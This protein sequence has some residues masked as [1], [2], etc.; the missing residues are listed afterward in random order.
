MQKNS[1]TISDR[2]KGILSDLSSFVGKDSVALPACESRDR[3]LFVKRVHSFKSSSWFA[4]PC[5]LSPIICAR[6]GWTNI[7]ID[8]LHCVGCQSLLVVRAP[9][10]FDPA[11]Y[12]ACQKRL[13]DQLKRSA[14]HPCCMWPSCPTPEVIILA[15]SGS[16]RRAVVVEDFVN[17]ALLLYSVG[18]DLPAVEHSF[19]NVSELDVTAL[20]SLVTNSPEFLH[21]SEIPGA[22]QSAVLLALTGWDL[23]DASKAF[24]GCTSVQC[25]LCMRQPG[26]WN[27][28]SVTDGNDR[29]TP[30]ETGIDDESLSDHEMNREEEA[31][32]LQTAA[33]HSPCS[34]VDGQLS[35]YEVVGME[36]AAGDNNITTHAEGSLPLVTA[37]KDMDLQESGMLSQDIEALGGSQDRMSGESQEKEHSESCDKMSDESQ[38]SGESESESELG[39]SQ[40]ELPS[41]SQEKD[42]AES[43]DEMS[44]ES[45]ESGESEEIEHGESQ[46]GMTDES[47]EKEHSES[48]DEMSDESQESGESEEIE[49][50]ES[51]DGMPGDSQEKELGESQDGMPG[52]SQEKDLGES[53]DGVIGESQE[54]EH[55]ESCDEMSDESQESGE[56]EEIELGESQ[57]GMPSICGKDDEPCSFAVKDDSSEAVTDGMTGATDIDELGHHSDTSAN[58]HE[59][60]PHL[61]LSE[62]ENSASSDVG[63]PEHCTELTEDVDDGEN[64]SCIKL[65]MADSHFPSDEVQQE[66]DTLDLS[67]KCETKTEL[68]RNDTDNL[69]AC[70]ETSDSKETKFDAAGNDAEEIIRD[71]SADI[72]TMRDD[73]FEPCKDVGDCSPDK[74]I[75]S[76]FA[77]GNVHNSSKPDNLS[78]MSLELPGSAVDDS[79]TAENLEEA[80]SETDSMVQCAEQS[81]GTK[82]DPQESLQKSADVDTEAAAL[83]LTMR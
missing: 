47:Q 46:D 18:K 55:S 43:Q 5:W 33:S 2:L 10:S 36:S 25:S 16:S 3:D 66:P 1:A 54:K 21:D 78:H 56:S 50:G 20:C 39:E 45:Q 7:D 30:V 81:E 57:D 77:E 11:I 19:L 29:E 38:E 13:E 34:V 40:D 65:V 52:E 58:D 73:T 17:K 72:L 12:D 9:S 24:P 28:I 41:E 51:Q 59:S 61:L 74:F 53:Q 63:E 69:D 42:L 79:E 31:E 6:Y 82:S 71:V 14:H 60:L 35:P 44:D 67:V 22:L 68:S 32:E 26:L 37:D 48:Y 75:S 80:I 23:S 27:Y 70:P 62:S 83:D 49:L 64:T 76:D 15:H 4:K 8:L